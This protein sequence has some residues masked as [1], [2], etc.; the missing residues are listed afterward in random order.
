MWVT[1]IVALPGLFARTINAVPLVDALML[2]PVD[3][4]LKSFLV[5][6]SA[7]VRTISPFNSLPAA[8]VSGPAQFTPIPVAGIHSKSS[9]RLT[10]RNATSF[11]SRP[12]H[13]PVFAMVTVIGSC[14]FR[15]PPL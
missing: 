3:S 13:S 15:L 10:Q 8:M 9:V 5:L 14:G 2:S 12:G 11:A 7:G 1:V 4:I 6:A